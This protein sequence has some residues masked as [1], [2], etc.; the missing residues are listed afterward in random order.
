MET[1]EEN[2]ENERV[3]R[4]DKEKERRSVIRTTETNANYS[5]IYQA[6]KLTKGI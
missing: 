6:N 1:L 2:R 5:L 3:N 4:I